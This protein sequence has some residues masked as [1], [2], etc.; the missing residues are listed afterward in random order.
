MRPSS[1]PA[2]PEAPPLRSRPAVNR[3]GGRK[4]RLPHKRGSSEPEGCV[5]CYRPPHDVMRRWPLER[6]YRHYEVGLVKMAHHRLGAAP[7]AK[8]GEQ[9]EQLRVHFFIRIEARPALGAAYRASSSTMRARATL[10]SASARPFRSGL[11]LDPL[12]SN[13]SSHPAPPQRVELHGKRLPVCRDTRIANQRNCRLK[14][15]N[16]P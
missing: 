14:A 9:M 7:L 16:H 12:S 15:E 10:I 3:N 6:S 8:L 13:T 5:R 1:K 4:H 2:N 11:A